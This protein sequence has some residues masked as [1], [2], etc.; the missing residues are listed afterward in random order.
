MRN[1]IKAQFLISIKPIKILWTKVRTLIL[2]IKEI[3][4]NSKP[5]GRFGNNVSVCNFP[6]LTTAGLT[7]LASR[8][9]AKEARLLKIVYR[10]LS[11]LSRETDRLG[12]AEERK[13][14]GV[15]ILGDAL[16]P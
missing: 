8:C 2:K 10:L 4:F 9:Y 1:K 5:S 13:G 12:E 14:E 15:A 7:L 11:L 3:D 16:R 6:D